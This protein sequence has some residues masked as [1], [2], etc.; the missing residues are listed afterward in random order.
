[1][2]SK[3]E[4]GSKMPGLALSSG[5][6]IIFLLDRDDSDTSLLLCLARC[7]GKETKKLFPVAYSAL[8]N[9][10]FDALNLFSMIFYTYVAEIQLPGNNIWLLSITQISAMAGHWSCPSYCDKY[11]TLY[12]SRLY[13]Q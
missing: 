12:A 11:K 13:C 6:Q 2:Y 5:V 10:V 9:N 4:K 1:M 3:T 8:F 7:L